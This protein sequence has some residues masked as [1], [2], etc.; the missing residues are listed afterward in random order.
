MSKSDRGWGTC[1][2]TRLNRNQVV[3]I[4]RL[5]CCE[6]LICQ[7]RRSLYLLRSPILSQCRDLRTGVMWEDYGVLV[8]AR[9]WEFW[10]IW[11]LFIWDCGSEVFI[12]DKSK[13]V[14]RVSSNQ[15]A[16]YCYSNSPCICQLCFEN[17]LCALQGRFVNVQSFQLPTDDSPKYLYILW[18]TDVGNHISL[19]VTSH[20]K[21]KTSC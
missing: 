13:V 1:V 9:A 2:V 5:V 7:R 10:V 15:W 17:F 18:A 6:N 14:S 20:N 11:S 16:K 4:L 21:N 19:I 8:T 12:K 3:E